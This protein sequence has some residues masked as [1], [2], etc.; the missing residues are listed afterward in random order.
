MTDVRESKNEV[1]KGGGVD[2]RIPQMSAAEK[3][4]A[5]FGFEIP[6]ESVPLP[7]CGVIYPT[8]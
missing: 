2:P 1:F 7:S 6:V 3:M 8:E 4:K 5:D